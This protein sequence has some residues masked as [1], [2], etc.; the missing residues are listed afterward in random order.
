MRLYTQSRN[1]AGER[2]RIALALKGIP[3]E[4]VPVPGLFRGAY[5]A[6]NPQGLMPALEVLGGQVIAQSG[7][8]LAYLEE[9]HPDPP[10]LPADLVE[11]AESRAFGQAIAADLHPLNNHRVRRYLGEQMGADESAILAGYHHWTESILAALEETLARLDQNTPFCFGDQPG[12]AD[13]HLIPQLRNAR[14]FGCDLARYPRLLAVEAACLPLEAFR[15]A[16]PET[17]P[18]YAGSAEAIIG[19]RSHRTV[20]Q[21]RVA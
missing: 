15:A 19:P 2:V 6:I 14:R 16:S 1:S 18:D 20:W 8:I 11:R 17:Q 10:L 5:R 9:T 4:Y 3:Y 13:L 12:W 7:A 21:Q